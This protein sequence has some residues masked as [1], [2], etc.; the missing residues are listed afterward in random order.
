M[1]PY[2][3]SK[4]HKVIEATAPINNLK[5]AESFFINADYVIHLAAK[6]EEVRKG[7][8]GDGF[9]EVNVLGT[10]NVIDLC[11]KHRCKL[12]NFSSTLAV[13]KKNIYGVSKSL[14][15]ELIRSY[16]EQPYVG[17]QGLLAS[18]VRLCAIYDSDRRDRLGNLVDISKGEWYPMEKL[19]KLVESIILKDEFKKGVYKVYQTKLPI[20]Y[21]YFLKRVI[22]KICSIILKR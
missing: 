9:L 21:L 11:L 13:Y 18:T 22:R 4:G 12:I 15:E 10:K 8:E 20:H 2:L 14:A 16:V 5:K 19:F 1:V 17:K 3:A 6:V 7:R